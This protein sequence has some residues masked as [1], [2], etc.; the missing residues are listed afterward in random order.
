VEDQGQGIPEEER[1]ALFQP[2]QTTSVR[3]TAGE[4]STGLGLV[5][6]KRIVEGHGGRIEVESEVGE[7]S[8]FRVRLPVEEGSQV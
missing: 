1:E 5:I 6:T 4:K 7:G 3:G 8:T 2:F